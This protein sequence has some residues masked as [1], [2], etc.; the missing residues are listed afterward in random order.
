[1]VP[2]RLGFFLTFLIGGRIDC[3]FSVLFLIA[4]VFA[5][6]PISGIGIGSV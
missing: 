4:F 5:V 2:S 6:D 3:P 1:M